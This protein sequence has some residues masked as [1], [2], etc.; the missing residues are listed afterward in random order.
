MPFL[1]FRRDH[2][3]STSG[4]ICRSGSFSVHI[5]DHLPFVI[6]CGPHRGSFAVRDH[7]RSNLG[8]ISGLG[9]ICGRGSFVAL[10]SPRRKK[11]FSGTTTSFGSPLPLES[12]LKVLG[13]KVYPE[14][15]S[16]I[17]LSLH[18]WFILGALAPLA[19]WPNVCN[20]LCPKM[21]PGLASVW[22]GLNVN[23]E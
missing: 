22:S 10:Y 20:M 11:C 17:S 13:S 12:L 9:I 14:F 16:E 21:L 3:R 2:L 1:V 23:R 19:T 6:I 4:I 15:S 18:D 5:G 7:F 8:T